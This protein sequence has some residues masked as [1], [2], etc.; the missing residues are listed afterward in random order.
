MRRSLV[1]AA[2]LILGCGSD[3]PPPNCDTPEQA[4]ACLAASCAGR[5]VNN[6][7]PFEYS[8]VRSASWRPEAIGVDDPSQRFGYTIELDR[9]EGAPVRHDVRLEFLRPPERVVDLLPTPIRIGAAAPEDPAGAPQRN[10]VR[11]VAEGEV[12]NPFFG[13]EIPESRS[14]DL[15]VEPRAGAQLGDAGVLGGTC[16]GATL[17]TTYRTG[18]R[19]TGTGP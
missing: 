10:V 5:V 6:C 7:L 3:G 2:L 12:P 11:K 15:R 13:P 1:W 17:V 9:C 19:F 8:I 14:I 4:E 18:R 16:V